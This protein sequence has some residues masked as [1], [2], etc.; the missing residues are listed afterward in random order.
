M[1]LAFYA[2]DDQ[3]TFKDDHA[4][5]LEMVN[6]KIMQLAEAVPADKYDWR[7]AEGVRSFGESL[8]H[9]AVGNYFFAM[10]MD[11]P[12]PSG[13]DLMSLEKT[14]TTKADILK[15]LSESFEVVGN[16]ALEFPDDKMMDEFTFPTGDKYNKRK[17]YF[18]SG[19]HANEHLGQLIAYARMNGI[20]PPW[21]VPAEG[22]GN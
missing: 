1:P 8:V 7:P 18:I 22:G 15:L 21:S 3:P 19:G 11:V 16:A 5:L 9:T 12:P 6:G 10:L 20:A 13:M 4:E 2:Q 14:V 17:L